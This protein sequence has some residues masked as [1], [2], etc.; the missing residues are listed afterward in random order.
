MM[1]NFLAQILS[2]G[3]DQ[4]SPIRTRTPLPSSASAF[5]LAEQ[6]PN[7]VQ[8]LLGKS[9]SRKSNA[10]ARALEARLA[11]FPDI[12]EEVRVSFIFIFI[13]HLVLV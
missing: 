7:R 2:K 4:E 9:D 6:P 3:P 1:R 11:G 12:L 5:P 10:R 13:L 8:K